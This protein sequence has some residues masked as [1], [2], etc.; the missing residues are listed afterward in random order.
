MLNITE[1]QH[2]GYEK[3]VC[4]RIFTEQIQIQE[5]NRIKLHLNKTIIKDF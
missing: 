1:N 5:T 4:Y 2:Q 3:I